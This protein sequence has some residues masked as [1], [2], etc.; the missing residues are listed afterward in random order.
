MRIFTLY[1]FRTFFFAHFVYC[2]FTRHRRRRIFFFYRT[3][4]DTPPPTHNAY[5]TKVLEV[6]SRSIKNLPH[7]HWH[8]ALHE[9][10][11]DWTT[12]PPVPALIKR[13]HISAESLFP[14]MLVFP[15]CGREGGGKRLVACCYIPSLRAATFY[16]LQLKY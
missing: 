10:T 11:L 15:K 8:S 4:G 9:A 13:T 7:T 2:Y 1:F 5:F 12:A 16:Q 6:H 14:S 3:S